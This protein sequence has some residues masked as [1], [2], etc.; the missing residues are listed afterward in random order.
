M[1]EDTD[2]VNGPVVMAE[3]IGTAYGSVVMNVAPALAALAAL[4][5]SSAA[6]VGTLNT[7]GRAAITAGLGF[8]GIGAA[9]TAGFAVAVRK[10]A[11]LE[12]RLSYIQG[13]TGMTR[14]EMEKLRATTIKLGQDSAYTA[15]EVADGFTELAKAGASPTQIVG[16]MGAAMI[17]LGQSSDIALDKAATTIVSIS[18]TFDLAANQASH[19]ADIIQGSANASIVSVEDLGV[20]MKYAGGVAANL[21]L[22]LEDTASALAIL[23]NAGIRGSTA[24][25]SLRRILLQLTPRTDKAAAAMKK[26]G[27]ITK[28]GSNQF[29]TAEGKAKSFAEITE[30]LKTSTKG[31]TAEM[32]QKAFATIFGDRAINSAIALSKGGKKAFDEM[33]KAVGNVS[34]ADVAAER[35]DNLAGAWEILKGSMDSAFIAMG[36]PAQEPLK[37]LVQAITK[38]VNSFTNLNPT[39]QKNIV[40]AVL[41]FGA[42]SLLAGGFLI[43]AGSAARIKAV[44][45][46]LKNAMI[47][48]RGAVL[49]TDAAFKVLR[50]TFKTLF[51]KFT[52]IIALILAL[53]GMFVLAYKKSARLRQ[54][55]KE[56]GNTIKNALNPW[57]E[58]AKKLWEDLTKWFDKAGKSAAGKLA[59]GITVLADSIV[60][61]VHGFNGVGEK[62]TGVVGFFNKVG[63]VMKTVYNWIRDKVIVAIDWLKDK[64]DEFYRKAYPVYTFLKGK[65]NQALDTVRQTI[66]KVRGA[67]DNLDKKTQGIQ[68]FFSNIV[69]TL[70]EKFGKALVVGKNAWHQFVVGLQTGSDSPD[71]GPVGFLNKIGVVI[72]DKVIPALKDFKDRAVEAFNKVKEALPGLITKFQEFKDKIVARLQEIKDSQS[73]LFDNLQ[74]A[75]DY[76]K[77]TVM[78]YILEN[79]RD[80]RTGIDNF[81]T[82]PEGDGKTP[83][84]GIMDGAA[85]AFAFVKPIVQYFKDFWKNELQPAFADAGKQISETIAPSLKELKDTWEN[86]LKPALEE[87]KTALLPLIKILSTLGAIVGGTLIVAFGIL[88]AFVMEVFVG[89]IKTI[90]PLIAGAINLFVALFNG[91][92]SIF[93]GVI[94]TISGIIKLIYHVFTG[95]FEA[96]RQDVIDIVTSMKDTLIAVLETLWDSVYAIVEGIV[97]SVVGFFTWLYDVLV[98]HSIVPD[99]V[100]A[101]VQWFQNM[102]DWVEEKVSGF[103]SA[104]VGWFQRLWDQAVAKVQGMIEA[105]SGFGAT[106]FSMAGDLGR[107]ICDGLMY[108]LGGLKDLVWTAISNAVGAIGDFAKGAYDKAKTLGGNIWEG[109]K[110]GMG[111]NSPSFIEKAM[112]QMTDNTGTELNTFAKQVRKLQELGKTVPDI[113]QSSRVTALPADSLRT[114]RESDRA[115]ARSQSSAESIAAALK[116]N[117]VAGT[118]PRPIQFHVGTVE[119]GDSLFR[120]ARAT[121]RMLAMAEGGDSQQVGSTLR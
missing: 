87:A 80:L 111:I 94:R 51:G 67:F 84:Q 78:P 17:T 66:D 57:V 65:F 15:N 54:T 40:R 52:I 13:I 35:L 45:I 101:I 99:M 110:E 2:I 81:F 32:K 29:Y 43:V 71:G 48:L 31:L 76:L 119:D 85:K 105:I 10:T 44:M 88:A 1:V 26:L 18:S 112:F 108:V 95:N 77:N 93:S 121:D 69:T 115:L 90:T 83:F 92:I 25:T 39:V 47:I 28:D 62:Q 24:G 114:A 103:V 61:M 41:L 36:T 34:A 89:V 98:G 27:I 96:A 6:T 60:A 16:G 30:I 117:G 74:K 107:N 75:G 91:L 120:K 70:K 106:L 100:N 109:F 20:S 4:R 59:D 116:A 97:K 113:N 23:G 104:V 5:A 79:L 58:K 14:G 8:V 37:E 118:E 42:F 72:H 33:Y 9:I 11:E 38:L 73:G 55:L 82:K 68:T 7:V 86:D 64:W 19:V 53:V 22:S 12:K 46:Q 56:M 49:T 50:W 63:A 3:D 102:R 21:G